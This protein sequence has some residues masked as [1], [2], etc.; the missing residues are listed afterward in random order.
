[1][2]NQDSI[3]MDKDGIRTLEQVVNVYAWSQIWRE[4]KAREMGEE[5]KKSIKSQ[6]DETQKSGQRGMATR[7][8]KRALIHAAWMKC[9]SFMSALTHTHT[10]TAIKPDVTAVVGD[11]I[12]ITTSLTAQQVH[13]RK[14]T[15]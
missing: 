1:M 12:A 5:E 2:Q 6:I 13:V 8:V 7:K 10:S 3:G 4:H 9:Q 11:I 15:L 14:F